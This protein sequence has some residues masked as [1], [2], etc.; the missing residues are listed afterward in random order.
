MRAGGGSLWR[1]G[2][3]GKS[4]SEAG[5]ALLIARSQLKAAVDRDENMETYTLTHKLPP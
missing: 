3:G 2:G 1:E 5:I 4:R